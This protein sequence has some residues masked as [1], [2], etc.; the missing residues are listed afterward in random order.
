MSVSQIKDCVTFTTKGQIV[1]PAVIRRRF[2]IKEG[3]RATVSVTGQRIILRPITATTVAAGRG[4]LPRGR[5]T[6]A[7]EWQEHKRAEARFED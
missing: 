7:R 5:K 4:V 1:I 2:E 3:S 6:L